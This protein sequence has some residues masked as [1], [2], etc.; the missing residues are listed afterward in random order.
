MFSAKPGNTTLFE[1]TYGMSWFEYLMRNP[2]MKEALDNY[3][4]PRKTAQCDIQSSGVRLYPTENLLKGGSATSQEVTLVDTGGGTGKDLMAF[5]TRCDVGK[6]VRLDLEEVPETLKR[7]R[8]LQADVEQVE[9]NFFEMEQPIKAIMI[10][11]DTA[12]AMSKD[13]VLLKQH[14]VLPNTGC[15]WRGS[16]MDMLILIFPAGM[17]RTKTQWEQL[18][19]SAGLELVK[20]WTDEKVIESVVEPRSK[21]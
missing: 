16:T 13:S 2:E 6:H 4:K 18:L 21:K 8:L 5:K 7:I 3:M 17:E 9:F 19:D 14:R 20:I 1:F 11:R 12:K 10:L 15:S